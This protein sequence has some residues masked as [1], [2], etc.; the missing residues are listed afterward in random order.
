MTARASTQGR[1]NKRAGNTTGRGR[2]TSRTAIEERRRAAEAV[3]L[4]AQ[5]YTH[6]QIADELGYRDRSGAHRAISGALAAVESESVEELR[7]V[8][9]DQLDTAM[10]QVLPLVQ[11]EPNLGWL[12]DLDT[13]SMT[14]QQL[15]ELAE[16]VAGLIEDKLELRL[17]AVDR[18]VKIQERRAKLHGVDAPI[19]TE[20]SGDG[21]PFQ[22]VLPAAALMPG[23]VK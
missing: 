21:V 12:T 19:R 17:K 10:R 9:D 6:Q 4:R 13:E 16:R 2:K 20:V 23:D 18:L 3:Q 22:V 1:V 8:M 15:D 7:K 11:G 14:P 5:G